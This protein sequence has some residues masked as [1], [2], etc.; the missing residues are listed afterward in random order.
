M[1]L[2]AML[3][4]TLLL[5]G[6]G[7]GGKSE[8]EVS[9]PGW[10]TVEAGV[11]AFTYQIPSDWVLVD[12]SSSDDMAVYVPFD[13]DLSEG[14]SNITVVVEETGVE[15]GELEDLKQGL[16]LHLEADLVS[17]GFEKIE[18]LNF[19]DVSAPIGDVLEVS[20]VSYLNGQSLYQKMYYPLVD[21]Y[22]ISIISTNAGDDV[23]PPVEDIAL[24]IVQTLAV[25]E[26]Q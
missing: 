23:Q 26:Q 20:F 15:A 4:I 7:G 12:E 19:A 6:C 14:T 13:A 22:S 8:S 3:L 25:E 2:T 1:A 18:N 24:N 16:Q 10:S 11:N 17:S 5:G 21:G 9:G